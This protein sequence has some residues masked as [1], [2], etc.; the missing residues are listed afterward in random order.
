MIN[1]FLASFPFLH[2]I[3]GLNAWRLSSLHH[4]DA[5]SHDFSLIDLGLRQPRL[6]GEEYISI[7]DEFMEAVHT[8]WPKAIVQVYLWE[9][10]T[11]YIGLVSICLVTW[12]FLLLSVWGFSNEVGFW[13]AAALS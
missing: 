8:R 2:W 3:T 7:V 4:E 5:F 12:F 10:L 9:V 1:L 11:F 6:E 13:N